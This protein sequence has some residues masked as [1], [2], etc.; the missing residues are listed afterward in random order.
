MGIWPTVFRATPTLAGLRV[1]RAAAA[2]G[3]SPAHSIQSFYPWEQLSPYGRL[4]DHWVIT[5]TD[6]R[7]PRVGRSRT[8]MLLFVRGRRAA[9]TARRCHRRAVTRLLS[10]DGAWLTDDWTT[11]STDSLIAHCVLITAYGLVAAGGIF[12]PFL[13]LGT[14]P[15]AS[16]AP[17]FWWNLGAASAGLSLLIAAATIIGVRHLWTSSRLP[18][19]RRSRITPYGAILELTD[20][21]IAFVEWEQWRD[22]V[23]RPALRRIEHRDGRVLRWAGLMPSRMRLVLSLVEE[24]Y[25]PEWANERRKL[26]RRSAARLALITAML[27]L[28]GAWMAHYLPPGEGIPTALAQG[29]AIGS[30][31]VGLAAIVATRWVLPALET[32]LG[33]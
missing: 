3:G 23:V 10:G 1:D 21:S 5:N 22:V 15:L 11:M 33:K 7:R 25:C 20:D 9:A 16:E 4:I 19:V 29:L 31:L 17:E 26:A 24:K 30:V 6:D 13:L 32:R 18:L 14:E 27:G 12:A 2:R 8:R 28:C